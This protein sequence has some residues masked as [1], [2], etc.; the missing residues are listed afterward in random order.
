[1][2]AEC[3]ESEA[4]TRRDLLALIVFVVVLAGMLWPMQHGPKIN[5]KK[6]IAR[7]EEFGLVAAIEQY[8]AEYSRL[9]ASS[10]ALAAAGTNDFT[11]GTVSETPAGSGRLSPLTVDTPG[12]T[13]YQNYNSEVISILRDDN[14]WPEA[15]RVKSHIYNTK[16]RVYFD[17]RAAP[18]TNSPGIGPDDVFRDPW[19]SPYIITLDLNQDHRCYDKTL[20]IVYQMETPK[21]T[22]PLM[23]PGEAIV[24]SFGPL[25]TV[26]FG[27]PLNSKDTGKQTI[28]TSF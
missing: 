23:V 12:E 21:P 7:S 6:M 3:K 28:I 13:V 2:P 9:P 18:D 10:N 15:A 17:A 5:A 4:F 25:K 1:M 19:G 27:Q 26:N 16:Q 20:N 24:W 11:F 22:G 8:Y 14:F